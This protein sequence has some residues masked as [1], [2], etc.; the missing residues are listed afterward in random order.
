LYVEM[1]G[2][3]GKILAKSKQLFARGKYRE[4]MELLNKL[5]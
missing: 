5:V 3:A 1:M 4:A 2:G